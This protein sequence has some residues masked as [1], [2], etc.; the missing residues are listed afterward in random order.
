MARKAQ[1]KPE[2]VEDPA[3]QEGT[4]AEEEDVSV[5]DPP[6]VEPYDVL[7]VPKTA[8]SDE[9]KSAYRKLALKHHPDKAQPEDRESAHNKFQEIAFAYAILSDERR[10]KRYDV[11]GNTAE[12]ANIED[13]DFKWADFF[14]EQTAAMVNADMIEQVKREY[15]GGEEEKA[16][17]LAAYEEGEGDM[18]AVFESVMC[19][20]VLADEERF[21]QMIDE[22]IGKG[23]V[24]AHE[25]YTKEGKKSRARRRANAKQEAQEARE[26]ARELGVEDKLFGK[27]SATKKKAK[28]AEDDT[29]ALQA[30]I[31]QR[32]QSREQNFFDDLEAKYGGNAKKGKRKD[33]DE[34]SEEAFQ[35]NAKKGKKSSKA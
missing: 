31:Q 34:P 10:R 6:T 9:I 5:T 14:R 29:D 20:E 26:Y 27:K 1:S 21:R 19:S 2:P 35:K 11:T 3:A 28:K 18:D 23:E 25:E 4:D 8:T 7:Q 30:L 13:D 15:Q 17:V 32:Q 22:A 24:Q 33:M 16:D 12:S